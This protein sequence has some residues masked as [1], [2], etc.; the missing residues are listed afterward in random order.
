MY[1]V[2]CKP[3]ATLVKSLTRTSRK[4][5]EHAGNKSELLKKLAERYGN[6][7]GI[8]D[9]DP[10]SIQPPHLQKFKEKQDLTRYNLKILRQTRKN[11]ILIMLRPRLED[12]ILEAAREAS[13]DVKKYNLPNDPVKLHEQINIQIGNFQKLVEDL[14]KSNRFRELKKHLTTDI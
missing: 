13:I 9:E 6:S 8:I 4:N 11:N 10:W 14:A 1:L 5:I 2:E 7:K 3:D 12:W